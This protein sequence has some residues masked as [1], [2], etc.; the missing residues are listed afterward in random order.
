MLYFLLHH[1][2][3]PCY[4]LS[5]VSTANDTCLIS[6]E[7]RGLG[8]YNSTDPTDQKMIASS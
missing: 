6:N 7:A 3:Y 4:R 2:Y 1:I 8:R 5:D